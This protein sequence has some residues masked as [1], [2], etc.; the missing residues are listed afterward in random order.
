MPRP[1]L[2]DLDGTLVDTATMNARIINEVAGGVAGREPGEH[3]ARS[4][5]GQPLV[6]IFS[7]LLAAPPEDER[8]AVAVERF[9]ASFRTEMSAAGH[10]LPFPGTRPL[11]ERLREAGRPLGIV[12]SKVRASADELLDAAGLRELFDVVVCHDM[13]ERGKPHPDPALLAAERIGADPADCALVGDAVVDMRMAVD[14]GMT[15]IG[16][17]YG[18]ATAEELE[19]SGAV[20]VASDP[21][22]LGRILSGSADS[23]PLPDPTLSRPAPA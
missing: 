23:S 13:V 16:V 22:E 5:I 3:I 6:T 20:A 12:T 7:E 11:L 8:V 21:A 9:R 19:A 4:K 2:F 1:A 14:A 18:V 15:P 17:A 10:R